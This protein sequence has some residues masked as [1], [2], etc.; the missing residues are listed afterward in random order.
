[1]WCVRESSDLA[2]GAEYVLTVTHFAPVIIVTSSPIGIRVDRSFRGPREIFRWNA[3]CV[4]PFLRV[5]QDAGL[6]KLSGRPFR[7]LHPI[8][9]RLRQLECQNPTVSA[10]REYAYK[11][12]FDTFR[13]DGTRDNNTLL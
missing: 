12:S 2:T 5:G 11:D 3:A 8:E 9:L 6:K 10:L 4:T 1:M 7:H 13:S